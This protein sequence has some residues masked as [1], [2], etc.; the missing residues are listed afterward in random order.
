MIRLKNIRNENGIVSCVAFVED[1][2]Q[3][4]SVV[5][6]VGSDVLTHGD[7]PE[8]YAWCSIHFSYARRE[9]KRMASSGVFRES[10]T[11]MWY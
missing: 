5:Y 8:E 4:I 3:G 9:L 7:I 6:D 10:A 11:V 1:C 2:E